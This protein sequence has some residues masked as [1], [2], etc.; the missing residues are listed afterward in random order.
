M[1]EIIAAYISL[2][3]AVASILFVVW[4]HFK[5]DRLLT[6]RV[7]S[8]YQDIEELIFSFYNSY[9]YRELWSKNKNNKHYEAKV[10]ESEKKHVFYRGK[11]N[12]N[13]AEYSKYLGLTY[14]S[15]SGF[16]INGYNYFIESN[17]GVFNFYTRFTSAPELDRKRSFYDSVSGLYVFNEENL[18]IINNFLDT[19]RT[20]WNKYYHKKILFFTLRKK[21]KPKIDFSELPITN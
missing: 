14:Y 12:H 7:K 5:D 20:H 13:F 16:Y 17:G 9:N 8:F 2:G 1:A 10:F 15:G 6:K 4:D 18:T 11:V 19:L 3:I 21:L